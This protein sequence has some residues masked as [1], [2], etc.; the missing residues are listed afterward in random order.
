M[1]PVQVTL[2]VTPGV[3]TQID[4]VRIE[5]TGAA[6]TTDHGK[7]II[8]RLRDEWLLPV[9]MEFRQRTWTAAKEAGVTTLAA[10]AVL[11]KRNQSFINKDIQDARVRKI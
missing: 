8:T 6:T 4:A 1:T 9:G 5:V 10:N 2:T 7:A 11:S 3:P